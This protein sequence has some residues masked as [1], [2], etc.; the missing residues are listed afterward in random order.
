[1]ESLRAALAGPGVRAGLELIRERL[2][3]VG[4]DFP[5]S[6]AGPPLTRQPDVL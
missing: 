6:S 3:S 4:R 1:M 2:E 5:A